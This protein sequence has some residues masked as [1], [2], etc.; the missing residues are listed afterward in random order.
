MSFDRGKLHEAVEL[1]VGQAKDA[2]T[3]QHAVSVRFT[4]RT[5]QLAPQAGR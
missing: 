2:L 4:G 3:R 1:V 5:G